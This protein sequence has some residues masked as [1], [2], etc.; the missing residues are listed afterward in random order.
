MCTFKCQSQS[1]HIAGQGSPQNAHMP[2]HYTNS[3]T[4]DWYTRWPISS[5]YNTST[6]CFADAK[7]SAH[8]GTSDVCSPTHRSKICMLHMACGAVSPTAS[9]WGRVGCGRSQRRPGGYMNHEPFLR[10]TPIQESNPGA[11]LRI[12]EEENRCNIVKLAQFSSWT[13]ELQR[14]SL[15]WS[16]LCTMCQLNKMHG[17]KMGNS[18][19][20]IS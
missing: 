11:N 13:T 12:D 9:V 15:G 16:N 18:F 4:L 6:Y 17:Y 3:R 20:F 1:E 19:K 7:S 2:S 5:H 8:N 14:G 10:W